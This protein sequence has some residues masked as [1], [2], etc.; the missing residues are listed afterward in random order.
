MWAAHDHLLDCHLYS[1]PLHPPSPQS[2]TYSPSCP[3]KCP[4]GAARKIK[5]C[6]LL[7]VYCCFLVLFF[8]DQIIS[9][10][11][12]RVCVCVCVCLCVCLWLRVCCGWEK[13][14]TLNHLRFECKNVFL[15]VIPCVYV[16]VCLRKSKNFYI[17]QYLCCTRRRAVCFCACVCLCVCTQ[18]VVFVCVCCM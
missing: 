7:K 5:A 15:C 1:P 9:L 8:L 6:F 12:Y 3:Q 11:G 13:V 2:H 14:F 17:K 16:C 18:A 4:D 10:L